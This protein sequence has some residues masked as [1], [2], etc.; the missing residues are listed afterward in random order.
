MPQH[1]DGTF[2]IPG[3]RLT[4]QYAGGRPAA[5]IEHQGRM[6]RALWATFHVRSD[7]HA[8]GD[9][10]DITAELAPLYAQVLEAAMRFARA[11]LY[12][13]SARFYADRTEMTLGEGAPPE[14]TPAEWRPHAALDCSGLGAA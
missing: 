7:S 10:S 9:D 14:G 12:L 3:T 13:S 1:L 11:P 8:C 2:Q 4:I 6:H 5:L